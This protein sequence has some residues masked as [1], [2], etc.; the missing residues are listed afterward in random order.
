MILSIPHPNIYHVR[1]STQYE[2][3]ITLLRIQEFYESPYKE[4]NGKYFTLEDFIDRYVKDNN[5]FDYCEKWNGFNFP[6]TT[7]Q[8]FC[9][10]YKNKLRTKEKD[11]LHL[12]GI[13]KIK[14]PYYLI[15]TCDDI[16]IKHETA[17]AFYYL[18]P[19]YKKTINSLIKELDQDLI[20]TYKKRLLEMEYCPKVLLDEIQA[21]ILDGIEYKQDILLCKDLTPELE[22]IY[23]KFN[24]IYLDYLN[25]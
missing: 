12:L 10:I 13:K 16:T 8:N 21:Y 4:I 24:N 15:A 25:G 3:C 20:I 17:H 1:F 19:D 11:F 5:K 7:L 6:D 18:Y 14:N 2:M 9:K 22:K 23:T